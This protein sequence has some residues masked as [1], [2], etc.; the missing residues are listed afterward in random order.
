MKKKF[1]NIKFDKIPILKACLFHSN[2]MLTIKK[3]KCQ[4]NKYARDKSLPK[5]LYQ[6]I[7]FSNMT[8]KVLYV[9]PLCPI[10]KLLIS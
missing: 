9:Y 8:L 1:Y 2:V 3:T 4:I 6:V 7:L 5:I 10:Y